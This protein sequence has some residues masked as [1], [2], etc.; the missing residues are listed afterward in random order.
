MTSGAVTVSR[1]LD[2]GVFDCFLAADLNPPGINPNVKGTLC[3]IWHGFQVYS[4]RR[5]TE[6]VINRSNTGPTLQSSRSL[7]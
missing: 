7:S 5:V 4:S 2:S 6:Q 3:L 1:R